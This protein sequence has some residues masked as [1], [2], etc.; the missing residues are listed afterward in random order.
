M[1]KIKQN[2]Y[3][4]KQGNKSY[5]QGFTLIELVMVIVILGVLSAFALP[6][7]ADMSTDARVAKLEAL[8]G[9]MR[10]AISLVHTKAIIEN[11]TDCST[12]PTIEMEGQTITL[13]CGY[14]CP[15]PNGI[16]NAVAA[17]GYTWIGGNCGGV[18]GNINVRINDAPDP[19][20]CNI[21]YGASNGSR[22]PIL[23]LTNNGC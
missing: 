4:H 19:I 16:G 18:L 3:S 14:P 15:H 7:F 8:E 6:R 11:K 23:T 10:S 1:V 9:A 12:D 13:R 22:P 20:D 2:K 5:A 17:D 21:R